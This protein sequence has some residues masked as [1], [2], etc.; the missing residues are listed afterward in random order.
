MFGFFRTAR[1]KGLPDVGYLGSL[2]KASAS[3]G[4]LGVLQD[5]LCKVNSV[6]ATGRPRT[7]ILPGQR[8][9]MIGAECEGGLESEPARAPAFALAGC[10]PPADRLRGREHA[11]SGA[12]AG[13]PRPA[14]GGP[15][16]TPTEGRRHSVH[17]VASQCCQCQCPKCAAAFQLKSFWGR[18]FDDG[19]T[20]TAR[21][22]PFGQPARTT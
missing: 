2:A 15:L 1:G 8:P 21:G 17:C 19:T 9:G 6:T 22:L 7:P 18:S 5:R 4:G 16:R 13:V 3:V 10:K 20:Q 14:A 12:A 11:S